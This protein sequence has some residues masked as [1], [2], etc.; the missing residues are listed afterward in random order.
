MKAV[1]SD[2]KEGKMLLDLLELERIKKSGNQV[3]LHGDPI[4]DAHGLF[5]YVVVHWLNKQG[6]DVI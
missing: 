3:T 6:F 2:C 5:V 4:D 1:V